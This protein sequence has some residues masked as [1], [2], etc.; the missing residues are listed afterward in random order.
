MGNAIGSVHGLIT[1]D[2]TELHFTVEGSGPP[3]LVVGSAIY[4]PRTFSQRIKTFCRLACCDLR[5]FAKSD[6]R[7]KQTQIGMDTYVNDIENIR[8][9]VGFER[10]A[11]VG[12][13]HHGNIALEYAKRYPNKVSQLVLIGTPPCD[14]RS[15]IEE[16]QR[17]WETQASGARKE[18]LRQTQSMLAGKDFT[19]MSP[20]EAFVAEYAADGPKYWYDADF[21]ATALWQGVPVNMVVTRAFKGLFDNYT[22]DL[23]P[24]KDL[25][26]LVVIGKH[27]YVVP[28]TLW[29]KTASLPN[30]TYHLLE[31]SGHTPQLEEQATFD[32]IFLA[33]LTGGQSQ[34]A[35]RS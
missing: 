35:E 33:W 17:Y 24:V 1:V 13:S 11:L 6:R 23:A 31:K 26:V 7:A 8:T 30:V 14:V 16:G 2:D 12:H 28:H 32:A 27:D 20:D 21:D 19:A 5:H 10:F 25:P 34:E 22:F 3:V 18:A 4:Y 29:D 9:V 15:T